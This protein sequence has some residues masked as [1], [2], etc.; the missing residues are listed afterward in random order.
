MPFDLKTKG[1]WSYYQS[2]AL[3]EAG[4]AH[5]FMT[6]DSDAILRD[7]GRKA[8]FMAALGAKEMVVLD[9][10]HG[11]AVHVIAAGERPR[12][13]DGLLLTEPGVIG[14]I[15]T[16]D[17]LPVILCAPGYPVCAIVHAGWRGTALGISRRA[18]AAMVG[19]GITA[20]SIRALIGPGIGPC[21]YN[22]GEDVAAAFKAAGISDEVFT[23]RG[24]L[25][26]LDLKEAN[27][28]ILMSD[29][30]HDIDDAR[31]CTSCGSAPFFSARRDGQ[32]GR[33]INF[34]LIKEETMVRHRNGGVA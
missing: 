9:Q 2:P 22:V 26:F 30:V 17:C 24:G 25:T 23:R 11:D 20:A 15:K 33:Q 18:V 3:E 7:A 27:R 4:I 5:G 29:G 19:L 16:A 34:V 12:T 32:A 8:A 28:R 31:L 6:R 10:Q 14:V 21:C 1:P 13:G